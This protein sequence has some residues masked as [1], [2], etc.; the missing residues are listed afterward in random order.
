MIQLLVVRHYRGNRSLS[1]FTMTLSFLVLP[2]PP[3]GPSRIVPSLGL[4]REVPNVPGHRDFS[5]R[6]SKIPGKFPAPRVRVV[7]HIVNGE[8][9]FQIPRFCHAALLVLLCAKDTYCH[10]LADRPM[11]LFTIQVP[12]ITNQRKNH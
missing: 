5:P 3:S 6:T 8:R 2:C 4:S 9:W 1:L 7:R 12:L 11:N 10:I